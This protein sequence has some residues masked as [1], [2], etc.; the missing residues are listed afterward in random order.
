M[1]TAQSVQMAMFTGQRD[2]VDV[3]PATLLDFGELDRFGIVATQPYGALGA[4]LL[5]SL[6]TAAYYDVPGRQRRT[7]L[8][9]P[10]IYA[11]HVGGPWGNL[12]SF[13]FWPER[14]ELFLPA[15]PVQV[16][17][18]INQCGITHL[19][20]PDLPQRDV[21]YR[22]REPEIAG[23]RLKQCYAYSPTGRTAGAD[24]I[25]RTTASGI[26]WNY[27]A[28]LAPEIY[29][30]DMERTVASD[31]RMQSQGP[32]AR[33][34]R[35]IIDYLRGRW[36]EVRRDEPAYLA[37]R[38]RAQHAQAAGRLEESYRRIDA[39]AALKLLGGAS[40]GGCVS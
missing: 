29:V 18:A 25:V 3:D 7:G 32:E 4:G 1:H 40:V 24:T 9:Y 11:F 10:E 16:L 33:D 30:E 8:L 35:W 31:S 6:A 15:D 37:A 12:S 14:K 28:S 39:P 26:L 38:E 17:R 2:G 22:Y 19:A 13:D 34:F 21:D 20:V 27:E 36:D 23:E 5:I